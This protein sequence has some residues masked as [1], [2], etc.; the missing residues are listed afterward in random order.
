LEERRNAV[1][2]YVYV[3]EPLGRDVVVDVSIDG[4]NLK[5]L[6]PPTLKLETGQLVWLVFNKDKMHFFDKRSGQAII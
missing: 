4:V 5:I 1:G 6:T 2:G 3:V